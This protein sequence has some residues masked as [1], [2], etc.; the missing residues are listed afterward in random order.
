MEPLY[1]VEFE[2]TLE[3]VMRWNK[4]FFFRNKKRVALVFL[5]LVLMVALGIFCLFQGR[6]SMGVVCF[7]YVSNV[8]CI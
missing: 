2:H 3:T 7:A 4:T 1:T 8:L 5:L 6:V